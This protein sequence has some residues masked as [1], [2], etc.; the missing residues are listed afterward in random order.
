MIKPRSVLVFDFNRKKREK[1]FPEYTYRIYTQFFFVT[2]NGC[3]CYSLIMGTLEIGTL[4]FHKTGDYFN[5]FDK[6]PF[7]SVTILNTLTLSQ[8][9]SRVT[10]LNRAIV[11]DS[12]QRKT[13]VARK[14]HFTYYTFWKS[15]FPHQS[16]GKS[17]HFYG[18]NSSESQ[19]TLCK[20]M[21][22]M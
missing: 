5:L 15:T 11:H 2:E 17:R 6:F 7:T 4:A 16:S 18:L 14:G 22:N 9:I 21:L 13:V 19:Q 1:H 12:D 3:F 10:E 20:F 8:G